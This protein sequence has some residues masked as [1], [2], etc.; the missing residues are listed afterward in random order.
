MCM[1]FADGYGSISS[2]Y[3]CRSSPPSGGGFGVWNARASSQTR[4]HL[5]SIRPGS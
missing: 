1:P 2:W 5:A 4:C 3:Q